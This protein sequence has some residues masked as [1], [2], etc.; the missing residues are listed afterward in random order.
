MPSVIAVLKETA[1]GE[2][3]VA[4]DPG[5]ANKLAAAGHRVLIQQGAGDA[6]GFADAQYAECEL[7]AGAD[8]ILPQADV[9]LWVHPP[10][11]GLVSKTKSG[12]IGIGVAMPHRHPELVAALKS[13]SISS[14]AMELV[15]RITRAQAMDVLSSQATVAGYKATL[16]AASLSPR[17][18]PMLTTAAGTI[19]PSSVVVI[20][21]G[22]AGLQAIATARRLGAR[23]HAYDIR[24]AAREQ[25]ESLGA[26]MIDTGV[27][28]EA[29]GGYAR[30]LTD[31]EKQQQA[32]VL[33]EHLSRA[34]A[35]ISTAAI[36]GRPAPKIIT[37]AMVEG[38]APGSIIEDLAAESGGNCE[39]T[40][41]GQVVE[42]GGVLIDG[43]LNLPSSA[44]LHASEMYARNLVNL[45]GLV[46]TD[47]GTTIDRDDEI[48]EGCLLTHGGELVHPRVKEQ[49]ANA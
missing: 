27:N 22:V 49:M 16:R 47:E 13:A 20:G 46:L 4:L 34:D 23:V 40:E 5:A 6:A 41:P 37:R 30:E 18:F 17:L 38:M 15:P 39:L 10:D 48:I 1:E 2:R 26:K 7:L 25:V 12:T 44:A 35:V 28:A 36:P 21:A 45:L 14:L 32:D 3:R 8:E 33:A 9:W 43:P 31:D 29:E 11:P 42:H 24:A 19:K